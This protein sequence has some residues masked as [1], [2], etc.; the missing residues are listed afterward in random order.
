MAPEQSISFGSG[1]TIV[2]GENAAGKSGY[3]RILKKVWRSRAVE[4]VLGD[5]LSGAAPMRATATVH[6]DVGGV[7]S[8]LQWTTGAPVTTPELASVSVFDTHCVP[9]YLKDKTDVAF[10][11]FSLDVFDKLAQVCAHVKKRLES[12][13]WALTSVAFVPPRDLRDGTKAKAL[14][15]RLSALTHDSD[16]RSLAAL[17]ATEQQRLAELHTAKTV[18]AANDP[19]QRARELALKASRLESLAG[20][21]RRLSNA[22]AMSF[23]PTAAR[24]RRCVPTSSLRRVRF[25]R[26]TSRLETSRARVRRCTQSCAGM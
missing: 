8:T 11:P 10:R 22:C 15:D 4:E 18:L 23:V 16:V 17:S 7:P 1:L 19:K 24:R 20:H 14:V 3:T 13:Q 21:A 12:E 25:V 2:Y 6:F 26:S 9:V 5:V